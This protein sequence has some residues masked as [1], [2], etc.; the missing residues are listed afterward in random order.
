MEQSRI[1]GSTLDQDVN[2]LWIEH[3]MN[4]LF[5]TQDS[6]RS[7]TSELLLAAQ[8]NQVILQAIVN[9]CQVIRVLQMIIVYSMIRSS[10]EQM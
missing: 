4:D 1:L 8:T 9:R 5:T 6:I 2:L 10:G 3:K 7:V